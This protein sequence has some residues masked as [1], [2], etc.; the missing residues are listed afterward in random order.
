[1][2]H[3]GASSLFA[4]LRVGGLPVLVFEVSGL[5]W[6][7]AGTAKLVAGPA[8]AR[9]HIGKMYPSTVALTNACASL[10]GCLHHSL[11]LECYIVD[12]PDDSLLG[13]AESRKWVNGQH[14]REPF[15]PL[16]A[17]APVELWKW[18]GG[19]APFGKPVPLSLLRPWLPAP[20]SAA[21]AGEELERRL[22][23]V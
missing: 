19:D 5:D 16:A 21:Q 22:A 4:F 14:L 23:A 11:L 7:R 8:L 17:H 2:V 12:G 3:C 9:R 18:G 20:L 1:M 13:T 10:F 15:S 6:F